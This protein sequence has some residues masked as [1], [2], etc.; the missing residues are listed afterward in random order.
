V[1]MPR[2]WFAIR[3][4][5]RQLMINPENLK[6]AMRERERSS[7]GDREEAKMARS[8]AGVT[9]MRLLLPGLTVP[10]SE[11][12]PGVGLAGAPAC[13]GDAE[14]GYGRCA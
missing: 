7:A 9:G 6:K 13:A 4:I 1:R 5:A 11:I 3:L 14:S 8:T 10:A 12:A 2:P